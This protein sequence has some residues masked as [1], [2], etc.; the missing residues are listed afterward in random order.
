MAKVLHFH[1]SIRYGGGP[2]GYLF[3]LR[4]AL[5]ALRCS[6]SLGI[7]V[8]E[9]QAPQDSGSPSGLISRVIRKIEKS[10]VIGWSKPSQ[11]VAETYATMD[12]NMRRARNFVAAAFPD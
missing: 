7:E 10:R 4:E 5:G 3:Q 6:A 8:V 11:T 9:V 12:F 1:S 2:A